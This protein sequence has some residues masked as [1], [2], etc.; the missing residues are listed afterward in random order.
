MAQFPTRET[1]IAALAETIV[2]GL[3]ANPA[4]AAS[5]RRRRKGMSNMK[6][7]ICL[8]END[9]SPGGTACQT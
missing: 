8:S 7:G 9:S 1:E 2:A 5:S 3:T 6:C 4:R